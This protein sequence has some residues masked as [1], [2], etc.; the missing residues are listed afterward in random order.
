MMTSQGAH[1]QANYLMH[2]SYQMRGTIS[3]PTLEADR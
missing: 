1:M 2:T 3:H